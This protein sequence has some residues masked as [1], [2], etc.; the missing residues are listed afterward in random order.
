M[1]RPFHDF[2][3]CG[4]LNMGEDTFDRIMHDLKLLSTLRENDRVYVN[5]GLLCIDPPGPL[6]A[7]YRWSR[8]DT[9]QKSIAAVQRTIF[10]ALKLAE[11]G[12]EKVMRSAK[13]SRQAEVHE[14]AHKSTVIRLYKELQRATAA[15]RHLRTTYIDDRSIVVQLDV[16]RERVTER[17]AAM[18]KFVE[19]TTT[20][21][22]SMIGDLPQSSD[23]R[24]SSSWSPRGG[25][26]ESVHSDD[27]NSITLGGF[28]IFDNY[29]SRI[30][31]L[32]DDGDS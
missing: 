27:F 13:S 6:T 19:D 30:L 31:E 29:H 21:Q 5:D 12:M 4:F 17:L 11:F 1:V 8:G 32:A 9:R 25:Y 16:I 10:D 3:G 18:Q 15:L 23:R 14:I 20:N 28:I 2:T 7:L 24:S 22:S 26:S